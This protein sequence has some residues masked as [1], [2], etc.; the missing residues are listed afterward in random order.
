MACA[1]PA[2]GPRPSRSAA[3]GC[4]A[5]RRWSAD[6][7]STGSKAATGGRCGNN[8]AES[9]EGSTDQARG[10]L[11]SRR[12]PGPGGRS[13]RLRSQ[14]DGPGGPE[15]KAQEVSSGRRARGRRQRKSK[16]RRSRRARREAEGSGVTPESDGPRRGSGRL[17][18]S[19][20]SRVPVPERRADRSPGSNLRSSAHSSARRGA[21]R[22]SGNAQPL[23]SPSR[24]VTPPSWGARCRSDRVSSLIELSVE[25]PR[26]PQQTSSE[27]EARWSSRA[28][29]GSID[30]GLSKRTACRRRR[31]RNYRRQERRSGVAG[32]GA[33]FTRPRPF[34]AG[35]VETSTGGRSR[36]RQP[37]FPRSL[38]AAHRRVSKAGDV[39][40]RI[41]C[42]E[43][44]LA[45][46]AVGREAV[47]PVVWKRDK[48]GEPPV[49]P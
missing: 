20:E 30:S 45:V 24:T 48:F 36:A 3:D 35:K 31:R 21:P 19:P 39:R 7:S 12:S 42:I 28:F 2:T 32:A 8:R 40:V 41:V 34:L 9:D 5:W 44:G 33:G 38:R 25:A 1:M 4:G 26:G 6:E 13:G 17:S 18:E 22:L 10:R 46:E 23:L 11:R 16:S 47:S 15:R 14:V 49:T 29:T 27:T 43:G 37:S